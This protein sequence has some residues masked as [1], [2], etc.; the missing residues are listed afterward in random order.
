MAI[1]GWVS[2]LV[3]IPFLVLPFSLI[4]AFIVGILELIVAVEYITHTGEV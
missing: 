1:A 3:I 2:V 4:G